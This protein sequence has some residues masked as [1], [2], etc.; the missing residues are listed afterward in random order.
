MKKNILVF[1]ASNSRNSINQ[2]FANYTASQIYGIDITSIDLNNYEMPIY[3]VDKE[4]EDGLPQLAINLVEQIKKSDG[5]I[6][7]FAEHNGNYTAAFKNISDWLSRVELKTYSD[8]PT[9]LLAASPG[10]AGAKSVLSIAEKEFKIR[11]ANIIGTFSL[12]S[13]F[14]NFNEE[15][16]VLNPELKSEHEQAIEEYSEVIKT[17]MVFAD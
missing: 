4:K 12:P 2:K 16:G 10:G 15:E 14:D 5:I 9:L 6:V 11:G 13:F 17:D 1:G 7:S 3:S 8:K